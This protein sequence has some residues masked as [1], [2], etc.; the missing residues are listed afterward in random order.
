M[1]RSDRLLL[2]QSAAI[3][4]GIAPKS[5]YVM[6]SG[7][8]RFRDVTLIGEIPWAQFGMVENTD[9]ESAHPLEYGRAFRLKL[10]F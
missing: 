5:L 10:N 1:N 4:A 6:P 7:P 3:P 9:A 2:L 8:H